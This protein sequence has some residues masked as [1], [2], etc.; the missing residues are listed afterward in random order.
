MKQFL[1][2]LF[3]FLASVIQGFAPT[4]QVPQRSLNVLNEVNGE[5]GGDPNEVIARRIRLKGAVQGGYYRSCVSNE[6]S[7]C[8]A[9]G[10]EVAKVCAR[11]LKAIL[12]VNIA[13][14]ITMT[15]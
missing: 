7:L 2:V 9:I 6:V 3:A 15:L 8:P 14:A 10:V 13:I 1:F 11:P 12:S 5:S 4:R